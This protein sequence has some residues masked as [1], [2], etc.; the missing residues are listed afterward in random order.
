MQGVRIA[1]WILGLFVLWLVGYLVIVLAAAYS[2][3]PGSLLYSAFGDHERAA[4]YLGF[5]IGMHQF[6]LAVIIILV[7]VEPAR[8]LWRWAIQLSETEPP[9]PEATSEQRGAG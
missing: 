5:M 7:L 3:S 9:P 1:L 4:R 2:G 8:A 6:L